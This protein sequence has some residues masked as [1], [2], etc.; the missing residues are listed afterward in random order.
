MM[1]RNI[2]WILGGIVAVLYLGI[3]IRVLM[4]RTAPEVA[5][6]EEVVI[7]DMAKTVE[8]Q[9]VVQPEVAPSSSTSTPPAAI[10]APPRITAHSYVV[11]DLESGVVK[12]SRKSNQRWPL[13]SLTKLM[14]AYIASERIPADALI[15]I[16]EVPGGNPSLP[17][18][19]VGSTYTR[20]E[21]LTAM[22][23]S[24]S[25]EAAESVAAYVGRDAFIAAMNTQAQSWGLV[26][27][28]YSDPTGLSP[29][30]IST[31]TEIVTL[32]QKVLATHPEL[33]GLTRK[34]SY[35]IYA[36]DTGLAYTGYATHQ[37]VRDPGFWGGKTGYTDEARGNLL[38]L[39]KIN[40]AL[41]ALV[42]LGSEQRFTDTRRLLTS[43]AD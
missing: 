8:V 33:I 30:N 36:S 42:V 20:N 10:P 43:T 16:V 21:A 14:T 23:V 11:V 7:P 12:E 22:L 19:T 28:T 25:N 18:I 1:R 13:A 27:T 6:T 2:Y 29:Q 31:A 35:T 3:G 38:S 24:S 32:V 26:S 4:T 41:R 17:G 15:P 9:Q 5:K 40:N 37:L 39:F 34:S